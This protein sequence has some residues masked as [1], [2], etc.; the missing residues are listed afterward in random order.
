LKNIFL[1]V[2][3]IEGHV[4]YNVTHSKHVVTFI[5]VK[6]VQLVLNVCLFFFPKRN[7]LYIMLK[8]S[9]S[10]PLLSVLVKERR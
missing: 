2:N 9:Y 7:H 1:M 3:N 4:V 10:V 6:R 5:R 8:V